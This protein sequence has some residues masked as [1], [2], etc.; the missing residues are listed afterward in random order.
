MG[1]PGVRI[2]AQFPRQSRS[3]VDSQALSELE[4]A[5]AD[6]S[7]ETCGDIKYLG[8]VAT[9]ESCLHTLRHAGPGGAHIGE[10][11]CSGVLM[12]EVTDELAENP[13]LFIVF[14]S[15]DF[16]LHDGD[17]DESD[18]GEME[19][20]NSPELSTVE[21]QRVC[22]LDGRDLVGDGD[23]GVEPVLLGH[24]HIAFDLALLERVRLGLDLDE[25]SPDRRPPCDADQSVGSRCPF[26]L[27]V[28]ESDFDET[29]D[30]GAHPAQRCSALLQHGMGEAGND[31]QHSEQG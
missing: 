19:D 21:R 31:A 2:V 11:E 20:R 3:D 17:R 6:E 29:L 12:F 23:D 22:S 18:P 28:L 4:A 27:L 9:D 16:P 26:G 30:V 15:T 25:S 13:L 14:D 1:C 5:V 7:V 24:F 8:I 10:L